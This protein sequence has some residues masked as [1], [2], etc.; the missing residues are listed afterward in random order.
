MQPNEELRRESR[1][2]AQSHRAGRTIAFL[3]KPRNQHAERSSQRNPL[4]ALR[5]MSASYRFQYSS[6]AP[7]AQ[8][9]VSETHFSLGL[10]HRKRGRDG[11]YPNNSAAIDA[12][13]SV[14][15]VFERQRT[16]V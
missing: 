8:T 12:L 10:K 9:A 6:L 15:S 7:K 1:E 11:D 16:G 14:L 13:V 3:Q 4:G 5:K 2:R